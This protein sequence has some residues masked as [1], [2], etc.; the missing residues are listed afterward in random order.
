[1]PAWFFLPAL[2]GRADRVRRRHVLCRR[3]RVDGRSLRGLFCGPGVGLRGRLRERDGNAV[4]SGLLLP[5]RESKGAAVSL[6]RRVPR[7]H[8]G[9]SVVL[10]N[11]HAVPHALADAHADAVMVNRRYALADS[12]SE[13][14]C[15][16]LNDPLWHCVAI[17]D[18]ERVADPR[19]LRLLHIVQTA[20]DVP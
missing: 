16:A 1:M 5:R 12:D 8:R 6:F 10:N 15:D 20:R 2:V 7:G 18:P 17:A 4:P 11:T 13:R 14:D 3:Q 19:R 9:G